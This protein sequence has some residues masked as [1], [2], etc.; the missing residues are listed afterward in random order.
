MPSCDKS[1]VLL[2]CAILGA[3]VGCSDAKKPFDVKRDGERLREYMNRVTSRTDSPT[4]ISE[5]NVRNVSEI[6][7][8]SYRLQIQAKAQF[9]RDSF[10]ELKKDVVLKKAGWNAELISNAVARL[11]NLPLDDVTEAERLNP[12]SLVESGFYRK[13][14]NAGDE[15]EFVGNCVARRRASGWDFET[16]VLE[17]TH[18]ARKLNDTSLDANNLK[19]G[20]VPAGGLLVDDL[21]GQMKVKKAVDQMASFA[22]AVDRAEATVLAR[23]EE[24]WKKLLEL[25]KPGRAWQ[26]TINDSNKTPHTWIM[27][28]VAQEN[29]G[30]TV[31]VL[32]R[33]SQ[34]TARRRIYEGRLNKGSN[35]DK[36]PFERPPRVPPQIVL[37]HG[38]GGPSLFHA[39]YEEKLTID[40]A[41]HGG[42]I[43]LRTNFDQG[44]MVEAESVAFAQSEADLWNNWQNHIHPGTQ[45]QGTIA[46]K[47]GASEQ[48]VLTFMEVS[49]DFSYVR[50][51]LESM[52]DPASVAVYQGY[53]RKQYVYGWPI[54]LNP[55]YA[56]RGNSKILGFFNAEGSFKIPFSLAADGAGLL[57]IKGDEVMRLNGVRR[58]EP[59]PDRSQLVRKLFSPGARLAGR[60]RQSVYVDGDTIEQRALDVIMTV[61]E[62]R[63]DGEYVRVV[64]Q[65][66]DQ[67]NQ[68]VTY[69][70]N[71]RL[72]RDLVDTFC[73]DLKKR[74]AAT[75]DLTLFD[76]KMPVE[77]L[78]R[79]APDGT[80]AIGI[81]RREKHIVIERLSLKATTPDPKTA[82]LAS[83]DFTPL[84]RE[85]L[86]K[87]V[88]WRGPFVDSYTKREAF[89]TMKI[90]DAL[91]DRLTVEISSPKFS[92]VIYEGAFRIDD[93]TINGYCAQ[94]QKK[95]G[96]PPLKSGVAERFPVP[97]LFDREVGSGRVLQLGVGLDGASV[98]GLMKAATYDASKGDAE[99]S[100]TLRG[101][102]AVAANG[103]P[104]PLTEPKAGPP[105]PPYEAGIRVPN[106]V[107]PEEFKANPR[108]AAASPPT[109]LV[110]AATTPPS[111]SLVPVTSMPSVTSSPSAATMPAA[112]TPPAAG[113]VS[114]PVTRTW[115]SSDGMFKV[116]AVLVELL[117]TNK[118]KLRRAD[119]NTIEVPLENLS[120]ADRDFVKSLGL[121]M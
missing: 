98:V 82:S 9:L 68:I 119:G 52:A 27:Q 79:L 39:L 71:L 74:A 19:F 118:V 4:E 21:A 26:V 63:G 46:T 49:S 103:K 44:D 107:S 69:E 115:T 25:S 18:Q 15:L 45:W 20:T 88:V 32:I 70:G 120:Q 48:I 86:A 96:A 83:V 80:E 61:A 6:T 33:H 57:G 11:R 112:S 37:G 76:Y 94:L 109:A 51:L 22:A 12:L 90:T 16:W 75:R 84:V 77:L 64:L 8:D 40:V 91:A 31:R 102:S 95:V 50:V 67:P 89:I 101:G 108:P 53:M 54:V 111:P 81:V 23:E 117:S 105:V 56:L 99:L 65:D 58:L 72:D 78:F 1:T 3:A 30:E 41:P 121:G 29:Q 47:A 24:Q 66:K 17:Q 106:F 34:D 62:F 38:G 55:V 10:V 114:S 36:G 2:L 87:G 42:K 7:P 110:A 28:F 116:D 113:A 92:P 93:G 14:G 13:E 104:L 59:W 60:A 43:Q 85:K 100:F 5:L 73:L 35:V 97:M